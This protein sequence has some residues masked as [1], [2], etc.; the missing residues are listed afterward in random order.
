MAD[1]VNEIFS[2]T[3]Q[4][5]STFDDIMKSIGETDSQRSA[6]KKREL[7]IKSLSETV[8]DNTTHTANDKGFSEMTINSKGQNAQKQLAELL[9]EDAK[10]IKMFEDAINEIPFL[11]ES[12]ID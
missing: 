12:N 6:R 5:E 10:K 8:R 7:R 1:P 2:S 11:N 3:A 9:E 4:G